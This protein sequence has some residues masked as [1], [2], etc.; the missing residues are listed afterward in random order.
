VKIQDTLL[1]GRGAA[2]AGGAGERRLASACFLLAGG[3][4][5]ERWRFGKMGQKVSA[6]KAAVVLILTA[7]CLRFPHAGDASGAREAA[8]VGA[9][10]RMA[11]AG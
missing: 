5:N 2:G 4:I 9:E 8:R 7:C 6:L 3:R 11:C 1:G 10:P